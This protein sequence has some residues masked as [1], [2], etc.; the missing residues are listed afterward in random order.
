[1][2]PLKFVVN[3]AKLPKASENGPVDKFA[4]PY[5]RE[6]THVVSHKTIHGDRSQSLW[7]K[8]C[9]WKKPQLKVSAKW[10]MIYQRKKMCRFKDFVQTNL[11]TFQ[12]SCKSESLSIVRFHIQRS[13][14]KIPKSLPKRGILEKNNVQIKIRNPLNLAVKIANSSET[15]AKQ[16]CWQIV[17]L[18][19]FG[20]KAWN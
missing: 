17:P 3:W 11:N 2:I 9:T 19:R 14:P 7:R 10:G 13:N 18:N 5:E 20:K 8:N 15:G 1:M 4:L 6:C 16:D 12:I